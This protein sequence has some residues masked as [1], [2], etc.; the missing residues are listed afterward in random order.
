[1]SMHAVRAKYTRTKQLHW[2]HFRFSHLK[3]IS[4]PRSF[5]CRFE[6]E[7]RT[8]KC[9][10]INK[11]NTADC[12]AELIFELLEQDVKTENFIIFSFC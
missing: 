5:R 3:L 11:S 2:V 6:Y 7:G 12:R 9:E 4:G 8:D 1:M 10:D